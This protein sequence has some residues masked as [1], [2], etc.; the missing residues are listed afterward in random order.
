MKN[1]EA[2]AIISKNLIPQ[3]LDGLELCERKPTEL[4][5]EIT[6]NRMHLGLWLRGR[7]LPSLA[8]ALA[9]SRTLGVTLDRLVTG[10]D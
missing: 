3:I 4:S 9:L 7:N 5:L 1:K 6:G 2:E 10:E 8:N